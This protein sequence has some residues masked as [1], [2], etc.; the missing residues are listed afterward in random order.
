[1]AILVPNPGCIKVLPEEKIFKQLRKK[2]GKKRKG[3]ERERPMV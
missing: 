2:G 1:M 3:K